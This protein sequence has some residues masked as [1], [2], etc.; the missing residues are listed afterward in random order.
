[1]SLGAGIAMK[2]V[3]VVNEADWYNIHLPGKEVD[4]TARITKPCPRCSARAIVRKHG[5]NI[6]CPKCKGRGSILSKEGKVFLEELKYH[7]GLGEE[8]GKV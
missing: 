1:M 2:S 4:M 7:L 8:N 6:T 3:S 5:E